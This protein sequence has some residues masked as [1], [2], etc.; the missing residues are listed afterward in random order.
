MD[1]ANTI[2]TLEE[3]IKI[4]EHGNDKLYEFIQTY[5][6]HHILIDKQ[7]T[8]IVI[9]V[10]KIDDKIKHKF[11]EIKDTIARCNLDTISLINRKFA[12]KKQNSSKSAK[13]EVKIKKKPNDNKTKEN[14]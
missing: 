8:N 12:I 11:N 2:K 4:V 13:S 10:D 3:C 7:L 14:S 6:K 1:I 9:G 5:S